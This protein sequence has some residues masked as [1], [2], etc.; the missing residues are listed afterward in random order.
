MAIVN[1]L[2]PLGLDGVPVEELVGSPTQRLVLAALTVAHPH[3]VSADRL[4]ELLWPDQAAKP[5]RL[6]DH[7]FRLRRTLASAGSD[8]DIER[9][10]SGY[11]LGQV[12]SVDSHRF[13]AL[14]EAA[15]ASLDLVPSEVVALLDEALA[16]WRGPP[17]GDIDLADFAPGHVARIREH[18]LQAM[19]MRASSRLEAGQSAAV[20]GELEQI[21]SEHPFDEGAVVLLAT[22]LQRSGRRVDALRRVREHCRRLAD[23]GLVPSPRIAELEEG[24]LSATDPPTRSADA[25]DTAVTDVAT[26]P[27]WRTPFVGRSDELARLRS[28]VEAH[29][30]VTVVGPAGV[31]KTRLVAECAGELD[32]APGVACFADLSVT[33]D[34]GRIETVVAGACGIRDQQPRHALLHRLR[35]LGALVVLDNCEHVLEAVAGLIDLILDR[36]SHTQIVA[37]SRERLRIGGEHVFDLQPLAVTTTGRPSPAAQ[38]FVDRAGLGPVGVG[39]ED[40][41]IID[42]IVR[43]LDGLP[44]AIELAAAR[45][46][47][48]TLTDLRTG[49]DDGVRVLTTGDRSRP[50]RHQSLLSAIKWSADRLTD[51]QRETL[52]RSSVFA[53]RFTLDDAKAVCSDGQVDAVGVQRA[54]SDLVAANLLG[55]STEGMPYRLLETIRQWA[56][57]H[58][59]ETD[60]TQTWA[61]RHALA[62]IPKATEAAAA[63]F[64]PGERTA[65]GGLLTQSDDHLAALHWFIDQQDWEH[66]CDL[67]RAVTTAAFF[68]G[69]SWIEPASLAADLAGDPPGSTPADWSVIDAAATA[70]NRFCGRTDEAAQRFQHGVD[71]A[72]DNFQVW[73]Q[74]SMLAAWHDPD[75]A[76]RRAQMALQC[77]DPDRPDELL[78][79]LFVFSSAQARAQRPDEATEAAQRMLTEA[80]RFQTR[81]GESFGWFALAMAIPPGQEGGAD[82]GRQAFV[83][84]REGR[85]PVVEAQG[86]GLQV[87]HAL[88]HDPDQA[89][90]SVAEYLRL[91]REDRHPYWTSFVAGIAVAW[92]STIGETDLSR[93][94]GRLIGAYGL[95][96]WTGLP[97]V[98]LIRDQIP[99]AVDPNTIEPDELDELLRRTLDLVDRRSGPQIGIS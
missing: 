61:G 17:L 72:P 53:G 37:T 71:L 99:V 34:P 88:S 78:Q 54:I 41:A 9:R 25:G 32:G 47:T 94:L 38:L 77:S 28:A 48:M 33:S 40:L 89:H 93:R 16:L 57:H 43:R 31:G 68:M 51:E 10:G 97:A 83:V 30:L 44:L 81:R 27:R 91:P 8:V 21:A 84:A 79:S 20:V 82:A 98:D 18:H 39:S 64:G 60:E 49:L 24:L 46:S 66:L 75:E 29:R 23:L 5:R 74:G 85:I 45:A 2:G 65:I 80:R 87:F 36:T 42:A 7:I 63:S 70:F 73:A 96:L 35:H 1:D 3:A 19:K 95:R 26:V 22:A 59:E 13:E 12:K 11:A 76:V 56:R 52:L 67:M 58:L 62:F 15:E 4:A 55:F 92:L 86:A 90:E 50:D 14:V 69:G 6:W